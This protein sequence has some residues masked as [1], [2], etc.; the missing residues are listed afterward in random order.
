MQFIN[1]NGTLLPA[2]QPHVQV[3][4][5]AF[6]WGDGIFETCKIKN[7]EV[8]LASMHFDRLFQSLQ[9]LKINFKFSPEQLKAYILEL[10]IKNGC[11]ESGRVRLSVFREQKDE[12]GFAI[13]ATHLK[14]NLD[15]WNTEGWIIGIYP[16]ARKSIDSFANLKSA[17]Y[18]PYLMAGL[19][20]EK[21]KWHESL[22]LNNAGY[23]CEGSKT[24][25]FIVNGGTVF[26]PGLD[27]GCVNGVMRRYIMEGLH[28]HGF[29]IKENP[30][31]TQMLYDAD[32]VFLTN[33]IRGI[34][35]VSQFD[36][37]QYQHSLSQHIY[38]KLL[39]S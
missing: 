34:Q 31:D 13:E 4:N 3:S 16:E 18:L 29:M 37:K 33:A 6:K 11:E 5:R 8:L 32:E 25:I 14:E 21:N 7:G 19:F 12:G 36:T 24:N 35:W 17:N 10:C 38:D 9:V 20:A 15:A 22:V 26:T 27:Q 28:S 2:H 39:R 23:I 1:L 30:I